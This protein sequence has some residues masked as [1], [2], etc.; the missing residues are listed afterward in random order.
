MALSLLTDTIDG[1]TVH[2]ETMAR[3]A[4]AQRCDLYRGVR[5]RDGQATGQEQRYEIIFEITGPAS[6][7]GFR[8]PGAL[9]SDPR[10]GAVMPKETWPGCSSRT[11]LGMAG[12]IVDKVLDKVASHH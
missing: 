6:A 9:E 4:N 2:D 5:L 1:P 8:W 10:A 3:T 7:S 12:T 11:H